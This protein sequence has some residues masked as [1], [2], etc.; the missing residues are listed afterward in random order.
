G[1]GESKV[2]MGDPDVTSVGFT[3]KSRFGLSLSVHQMIPHRASTVPLPS[4]DRMARV[5]DKAR[6][7]T[8]IPP[9]PQPTSDETESVSAAETVATARQMANA[10]TLT[11]TPQ[12]VTRS[13]SPIT[14]MGTWLGLLAASL[15]ELNY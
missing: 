12:F 1:V 3:R 4:T 6:P 13:E 8:W 9:S 7:A 14:R 2:R 10:S 15:A 5:T 11:L